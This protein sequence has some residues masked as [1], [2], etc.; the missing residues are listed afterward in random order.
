MY[1]DPFDCHAVKLHNKLRPTSLSKKRKVAAVVL[2]PK[3][4]LPPPT[5][6]STRSGATEVPHTSPL[7]TA[8]KS[9]ALQEVIP[10]APPFQQHYPPTLPSYHPPS[11]PVAPHLSPK[12]YLSV[13]LSPSLPSHVGL[14]P[15]NGRAALMEPQW[16]SG[17][18]LNGQAGASSALSGM[19]Y[20]KEIGEIPGGERPWKRLRGEEIPSSK[21]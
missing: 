18:Q 12:T 11:A 3:D 8:T 9:P 17:G 20:S 10:L 13:M 19:S 14:S 6:P 7:S 1:T 21:V 5:E 16:S 2:S 4:R 15:S